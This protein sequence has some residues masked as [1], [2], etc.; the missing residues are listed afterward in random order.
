V[1]RFSIHGPGHWTRVER[2]GLYIA[3]KTGADKIVVSLFAVFHDC[4]R[5][6]DFWDSGHGLRGAEFAQS[7]RHE[8]DFLTETQFKTLIYACRWHTDKT[9]TTDPTVGA[10]WDADRLDLRRIGRRPKA[11]FLNTQP[12][13]DIA[14]QGRFWLLEEMKLRNFTGR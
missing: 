1:G 11:K 14:N 2:N 4:M 5:K 13:K 10:C 9:H 7:I 12:A 3:E 8:L 6:N